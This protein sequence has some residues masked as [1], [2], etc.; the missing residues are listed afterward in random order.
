MGILRVLLPVVLLSGCASANQV[1]SGF[2]ASA[3]VAVQGAEDNNIKTWVVDACGT[4]YSAVIRNPQIAPAL[5][6][7]CLPAGKQVS[8][9]DLLLGI[10]PTTP[11]APATST[12]KP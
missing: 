3:L 12:V 10:Q 7:L 9:A 4:P 2:G 5:I 11:A 1:Y 8:A 6:T